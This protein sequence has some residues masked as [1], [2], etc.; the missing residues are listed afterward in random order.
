MSL[1][2]CVVD[3]VLDLETGLSRAASS[4]SE[5]VCALG[6]GGSRGSPFVRVG[7]ARLSPGLARSPART[8][9]VH[10]PVT[11]VILIVGHGFSCVTP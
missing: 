4:P 7:T 2:G 1:P 9:T 6:L 8:R 3:P 11:H 5:R 10:A